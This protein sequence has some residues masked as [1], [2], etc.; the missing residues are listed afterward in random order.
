VLLKLN[1][2]WQGKK[3]SLT[4]SARFL[5]SQYQLLLYTVLVKPSQVK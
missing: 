2:F 1:K 3:G 5:A 4:A